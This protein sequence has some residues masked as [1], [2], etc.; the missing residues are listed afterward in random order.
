MAF[1]DINECLIEEVKRYPCLYD[2][3]REDYKDICKKKISWEAISKRMN[4][5]EQFLRKRWGN[6]RDRYRKVVKERQHPNDPT[7]CKKKVWKY[8]KIL[9]FLTSLNNDINTPEPVDLCHS[10]HS[11]CNENDIFLSQ[12]ASFHISSIDDQDEEES[13][14]HDVEPFSCESSNIC[15]KS[16]I[17]S[18]DNISYANGT[19]RRKMEENWKSELIKILKASHD[20]DLIQKDSD[21]YYCLSLVDRFKRIKSNKIK[22]KLRLTIEQAFA[23]AEDCE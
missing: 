18:N 16:L 7:A 21:Y 4:I 2:A 11:V 5:E 8:S 1:R 3:T 17:F 10:T 14:A 6:L 19:K 15:D 13:E 20:E 12:D 22:N 23:D 9:T